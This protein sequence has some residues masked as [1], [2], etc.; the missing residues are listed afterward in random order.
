[1]ALQGF[2]SGLLPKEFKHLVQAFHLA[3]RLRQMLFESLFQLR[4]MSRLRHLR[5]C[6]R[7]LTFG[8]QKIL[9]LFDE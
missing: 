2:G 8:M 5:Q 4:V 3:F 1:M 6:C 7:K 9:Q